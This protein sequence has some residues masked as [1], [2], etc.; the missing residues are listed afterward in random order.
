[1][2]DGTAVALSIIVITIVLG[3]GV[4]HAALAYSLLRYVLSDV[5]ALCSLPRT[6]SATAVRGKALA[7]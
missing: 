5:T 4:V 1:V 7:L 2:C 3:K 6:S